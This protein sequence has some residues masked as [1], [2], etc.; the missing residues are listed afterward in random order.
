MGVV[1]ARAIGAGEGLVI[2]RKREGRKSF[3]GLLHDKTLMVDARTFLEGCDAWTLTGMQSVTREA[4][5]FLVG[6]AVIRGAIDGQGTGVPFDDD[7]SK[8]VMAS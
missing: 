1:P 5:S 3:V 8:A 7:T 6:M 4:K 2:S